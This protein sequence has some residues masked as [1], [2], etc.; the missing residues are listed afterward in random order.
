MRHHHSSRRCVIIC[1]VVTALHASLLF[2]A[3]QGSGLTRAGTIR[4]F[5]V[6]ESSGLAASRRFPGVIWTH[7]DGSSAFLF[8]MR[9][10][11]TY[12]RAFPVG[13]A[14][15]VDWEDIAI[16]GS[17]NLYLAD[18]GANGM[19]RSHVAVHRV[20]EPNP[21]RVRSVPI[22]QTWLLR[23]P[24]RRQDCEAIFVSKGV[25]Y[26]VTKQ[27][28][29]RRVAIYSFPLAAREESILLHQIATVD[30]PAPVTAADISSDSRR[31]A[32]LTEEGPVVYAINGNVARIGSAPRYFQRFENSF[33]EG[34]CFV[35][36]GL[37]VS[38]ETRQLWFFTH[39]AF[40]AR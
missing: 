2:A 4:H 15:F 11:G 25:G 40:R 24:G 33:M 34:A 29:G 32:L 3:A 20:R 8:A 36:R 10:N 22:E 38:A 9:Q 23:F 14:A 5:A 7:N 13:G 39:P 30:V 16:D 28:L 35:G 19:E 26:L 21:N 37:L 12:I 18:T 17:G 27:R 6:S 1:A 31:L